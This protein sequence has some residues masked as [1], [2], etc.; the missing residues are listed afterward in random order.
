MGKHIFKSYDVEVEKIAY[1]RP[2]RIE[3]RRKW[4]LDEEKEDHH[5]TFYA[6]WPT[7]HQNFYLWQ[8][9]R[10]EQMKDNLLLHRMVTE[11]QKFK[12]KFD[13]EKTEEI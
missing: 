2:T 10:S 8:E 13:A 4:Q 12:M 11:I 7:Q 9:D 1:D 3:Q 5:E 6:P